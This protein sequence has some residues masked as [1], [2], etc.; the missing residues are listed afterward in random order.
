MT[1][2]ILLPLPAPVPVPFPIPIL[3]LCLCPWP[4]LY[5]HIYIPWGEQRE[6]VKLKERKMRQIRLGLPLL[7]QFR[8]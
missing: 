6:P 4:C 8:V 3:K 7:W 5:V 1:I 2:P